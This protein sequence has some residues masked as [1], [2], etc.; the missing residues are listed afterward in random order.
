M[1]AE[2]KNKTTATVKMIFAISL[3]INAVTET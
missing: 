1:I 2:T 3:A